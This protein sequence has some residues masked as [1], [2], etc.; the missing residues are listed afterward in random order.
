VSAILVGSDQMFI[1]V[2]RTLYHLGKSCP[3]DLSI[4]TIDD[5]PLASVFNPRITSVRQPIAEMAKA[6]L[7]LLLRR[8]S[9]GATADPR[10]DVLEPTLIVRDSCAPLAMPMSVRA[11]GRD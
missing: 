4:V 2:M 6:A 7:K 8:M 11:A 5:F 9:L 10:H 1:G 3:T